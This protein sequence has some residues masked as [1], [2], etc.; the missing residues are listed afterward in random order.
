[1]RF[2][3]ARNL[4]VESA[5][6]SILEYLTEHVGQSADIELHKAETVLQ[7]SGSG[8]IEERAP[9]ALAFFELRNRAGPSNNIMLVYDEWLA[10]R[11]LIFQ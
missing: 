11:P 8:A 3:S 10:F 5:P 9:R 4:Q 1:M 6:V 2:K 7:P